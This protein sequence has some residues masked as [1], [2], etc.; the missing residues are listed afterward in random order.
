LPF[1]GSVCAVKLLLDQPSI[2]DT[3]LDSSSRSILN[4]ATSQEVQDV[5][6]ASRQ[7]LQ[8]RFLKLLSEYTNA[9]STAKKA[10]DGGRDGE[11]NKLLALLKNPRA[12]VLDLNALDASKGVSALHEAVRSVLLSIF[13]LQI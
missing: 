6:T 9:P 10:E 13:C 2:D 7:I 5:I 12:G 8:T 3:L 11:A 1:I 4:A